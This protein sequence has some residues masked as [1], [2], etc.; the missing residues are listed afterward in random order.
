MTAQATKKSGQRRANRRGTSTRQHVLDVAL[1]LLATGKPEV[2][3]ANMVVKEAAVTWGTVQYQFGDVDGLW[4]ATL[5]H[6]LETAGPQIWARPSAGSI[7]E[8]VTEV[9]NLLWRAFD[10]PYN[11]AVSNLR[12]TL[13]KDRSELQRAYP[14]TAYALDAL[15]ENWAQ[16]FAEFFDG[17]IVDPRRARQMSAL[18][19]SA[20][21]GLYLDH[22]FG[23]RLNVDDA[24]EGL[25]QAITGYMTSQ[26][27]ERAHRKKYAH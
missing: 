16:Q 1:R 10:S 4:A 2:V 3:S 6:V 5:A 15:D 13:A 12:A 7:D 25:R 18:L 23:L 17:V 24:L 22:A 27:P 8:R 19:P 9:I 14:K 21:R 11:A 20:L 26:A